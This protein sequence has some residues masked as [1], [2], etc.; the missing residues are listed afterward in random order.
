MK[1]DIIPTEI[2]EED[3]PKHDRRHEGL[4]LIGFVANARPRNLDHYPYGRVPV[5]VKVDHTPGSKYT[6]EMLRELRKGRGAR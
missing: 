5:H 6:G 2:A 3:Y 4:K 1:I